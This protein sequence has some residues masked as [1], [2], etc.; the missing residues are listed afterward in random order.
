[1][2]KECYITYIKSALYT[3]TRFKRR[4]DLGMNLPVFSYINYLSDKGFY[5]TDSVVIPKWDFIEYSDDRV[6]L[7]VLEAIWKILEEKL[8][9]IFKQII[10]EEEIAKKKKELTDRIKIE[11]VMSMVTIKEGREDGNVEES[12][13][14]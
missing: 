9:M 1:M 4:V 10:E 5:Y 3:F 6:T 14:S 8:E 12:H 11:L 7:E 2:S 13:H